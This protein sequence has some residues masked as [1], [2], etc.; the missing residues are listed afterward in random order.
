MD[1]ANGHLERI[2]SMSQSNSQKMQQHCLL[3]EGLVGQQQLLVS[4][5]VEMVSAT[6]SGRAKEV[7]REPEEPHEPQGEGSGGQEGTEDVP[8]KGL[9]NVPE[10]ELENGAGV[11]DG[12]EEDG[13]KKDKGKQKAI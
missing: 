8:G 6:G 5:L 7:I 2:A 10:N 3:M 11:E 13:Q 4:K 1:V 9:G 12:T